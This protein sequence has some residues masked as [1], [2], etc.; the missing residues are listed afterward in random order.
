MLI[1][2]MFRMPT[3]NLKCGS[4]LRMAVRSLPLRWVSTSLMFLASSRVLDRKYRDIIIQNPARKKLIENPFLPVICSRIR[5]A[6]TAL[7]AAS[8]LAAEPWVP[9]NIPCR[10]GGITLLIMLCQAVA[11]NPPPNP[12]QI[13][14]IYV[15]VKAIRTSNLGKKKAIS[16][17]K[18]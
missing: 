15:N 6:K 16:P 10:R 11:V 3:N 5:P 13:R 8:R 2:I 7:T 12:C 4:C 18:K 1:W 9:K 14:T 17:K